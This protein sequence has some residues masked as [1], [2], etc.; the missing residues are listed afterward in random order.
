[1]CDLNNLGSPGESQAAAKAGVAYSSA[2]SS[3]YE[4]MIQAHNLSQ[5]SCASASRQEALVLN[6]KTGLGGGSEAGGWV[7]E[8]V[9]EVA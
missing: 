4:V 7:G 5:D 2:Y 1:M 6:S 3:R 8:W 9:N